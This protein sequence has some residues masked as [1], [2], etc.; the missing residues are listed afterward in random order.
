MEE[1]FTKDTEKD[2]PVSYEE[3]L[4]IVISLKQSG[5]IV[6]RRKKQLPISEFD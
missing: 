2:K 4:E 3:N 6:S 1:G 5:N